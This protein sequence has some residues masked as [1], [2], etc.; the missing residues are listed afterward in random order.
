MS[1]VT[2]AAS[3]QTS[4][5]AG[6]GGFSWMGAIG[7]GLTLL[8]MGAGSNAQA[9]QAKAQAKWIAYK[10]AMAKISDAQNQNAITD[11]V[12]SEIQQSARIA[13]GIQKSGME[14]QGANEVQA[15]A[16]GVTGHSVAAVERNLERT[17]MGAEANRRQTLQDLFTSERQLRNNS[18]M[19][20][21]MGQSYSYIPQQSSASSML[22][23]GAGIAKNY[24]TDIGKWLGNQDFGSIG[25]FWGNSAMTGLT[26][27]NTA[28]NFTTSSGEIVGLTGG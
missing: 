7:I 15:A 1:L 6:G 26:P 13:M 11:N 10:N 14:V 20:A 25:N 17:Q 9:A 18:A 12:V 19:S 28:H 21:A 24:G 3:T 8:S 4:A 23:L 22:G 2:T 27:A 16:A 5:A